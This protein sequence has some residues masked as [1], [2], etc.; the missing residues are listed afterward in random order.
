MAYEIPAKYIDSYGYVTQVNG[1]GGDTFHRLGFIQIAN[2]FLLKH[3]QITTEQFIVRTNEY[4]A[5]SQ[6]LEC[7]G[8]PGV[9]KRHPNTSRW[10]GQCDRMSRD[11]ITPNIV[12]WGLMGPKGR[13]RELLNRTLWSNMKRLMLFTTNTKGNSDN[14]PKDSWK[15]PDFTGPHVWAMYIRAYRAWALYPLLMVLDIE[16]L[17]SN[18]IKHFSYFKNPNNSDDLNNIAYLLQARESMPTPISWLSRMIYNFRPKTN[19]TRAGYLSEYGPQTALDH[20]FAPEHEGPP[21]N[22]LY[23]PFLEKEFRLWK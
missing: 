15:L 1:D 12:A 8:R 22:E 11:Q 18:I 7:K 23:R 21:I 14:Y 19:P 6:A 10:Y 2:H 16:N 4:L 13:G 5:Q 20:Y 9:F 3:K 17:A